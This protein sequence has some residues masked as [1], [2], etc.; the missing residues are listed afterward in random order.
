MPRSRQ[1]ARKACAHRFELERAG[2]RA[3]RMI[4]LIGRRPEQHVHR[5]ADDLYDGPAMGKDDV[6]HAAEIVVQQRGDDFEVEGLD[7]RGEFG[8]VGK[9]RGDLAPLTAE[10]DRVGIARQPLG[11]IG[12][13]IARQQRMRALGLGL[14]AP[15]LAQPLDM[16]ERLSD[17]GFEIGE[18]D[19]LGHEIER[20]AVHR[21]A[22]IGH[23]AIGRDDDGRERVVGL[24]DFLQQGQTV[25]PRHVDVAE[26]H[27]DSA[28]RWPAFRAPRRRRGQSES[29]TR[30]R[31]S[32]G[33]TAAGPAFPDP[34]RRRPRGSSRS[35]PPPLP[36]PAAGIIARGK[37]TMN[38]VNAPGS[39]STSKLPPCC[40][41]MMSKLSDRPRPVPSPAGLVV[42]NGSKI[43]ARTAS[44]MPV[45][46]SRTRISTRSPSARVDTDNGRLI[47]RLSGRCAGV[48]APHRSRCRTGSAEP[49]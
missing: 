31:G 48:R 24:L 44:G 38:S 37:V 12:R 49:A 23:V 42:K 14:P 47:T 45:P 43:F 5:V 33:E 26:H 29:R 32:G 25:H 27:V 15:R 1:R 13:E 11:Q 3:R 4:G 2:D 46:L 30:R 18:I 17:G 35:C 28:R 22:D 8:D 40:L 39:V 9:Q 10:V 16:R 34:A 6:G 36:A 20:P 21:G 41:T 19:R 7:H